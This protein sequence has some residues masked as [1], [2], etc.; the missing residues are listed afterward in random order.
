M[1]NRICGGWYVT[2]ACFIQRNSEYVA[3]VVLSFLEQD[4]KPFSDE[5]LSVYLC[6]EDIVALKLNYK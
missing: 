3:A 1:S 5:G 2:S 4:F 6:R